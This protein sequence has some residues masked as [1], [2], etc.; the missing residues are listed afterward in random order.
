MESYV[1]KSLSVDTA[2]STCTDFKFDLDEVWGD[3]C[4]NLQTGIDKAKFTELLTAFF[5]RKF[6][7]QIKD[8]SHYLFHMVRYAGG[9]KRI[10]VMK[11]D[12]KNNKP[13]GKSVMLLKI[14]AIEESLAGAKIARV[15]AGTL[16]GHA[17]AAGL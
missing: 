16:E 9:L 12:E 6:G 13:Y 3:I 4:D 17:K 15:N 11:R 14:G 1:N 10:T 8:V 7:D 2:E 5:V